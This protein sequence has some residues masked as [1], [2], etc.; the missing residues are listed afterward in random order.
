MKTKTTIAL[1]ASALIVGFGITLF[2]HKTSDQHA[3]DTLGAQRGHPVETGHPMEGRREGV[4]QPAFEDAEGRL[5]RLEQLAR[6]VTGS[7]HA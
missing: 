5:Q 6:L 7:A 2:L 3:L 4:H 1:V